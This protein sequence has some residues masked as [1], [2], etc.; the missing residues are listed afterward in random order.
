MKQALLLFICYFST[1]AIFAQDSSKITYSEEPDTLVK[2]R[3]IDR[4][5]NVF[6]TKVPTRHMFK[7]G[8]EFYPLGHLEYGSSNLHTRSLA[9]GYEYK[10][11]P[12]ISL[13]INLKSNG[14]W[15]QSS[16][17]SGVWLQTFRDVGILI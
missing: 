11:V 13:G 5:E 10:L 7:M 12:S 15:S 2:Q 4:F 8:I 16:V 9:L 3:F 6:M 1:L 17:F 14:G